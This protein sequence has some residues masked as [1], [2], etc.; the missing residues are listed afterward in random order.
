MSQLCLVETLDD[1]L[2]FKCWAGERREI[3]GV[4]TE[5]SGVDWVRDELRLLCVGDAQTG[6]ALPARE[7]LGP[8]K[9]VVEAYTE[10]I[11]M[12]NSKFDLHFLQRWG[13]DVPT[14]QLHDTML[15]ARLS[16][17]GAP[18][19]LKD[20]AARYVDPGMSV[21][22]D[23]LQRHMTD[24]RLTWGNIP[25]DDPL[26]WS[27]GALDGV[28]TCQLFEAFRSWVPTPIYQLE[29]AVN[30]I[31]YR[32]ELAGIEVDLDYCSRAADEVEQRVA[33]LLEWG[34]EAYGVRNLMS[35]QQLA[36][37]LVADGW[38]PT[39]ITASGAPSTKKAVLE[40]VDHPLATAAIELRHLSKVAESYLR[41]F[42]R[43][44]VDGRIFATTNTLEARTGRMS[45]TNP[46]L[47][48]LTRGDPI[49]RDAFVA[50]QG[51]KL[52]LCDYD[53][54]EL[55]LLASFARE[56]GL[57]DV[58]LGGQDAFTWIAQQIYEDPD[59]Q[60]NDPRRQ[61][62]KN[63]VYAEGYGAGV[64]KM[65]ETAGV[66]YGT[67]QGFVGR[68]R[69]QFPGI[70][71]FHSQVQ[72]VAEQRAQTEGRAYVRTQAGRRQVLP[73]YDER[74][75]YKLVNYL[76]QGTAADVL[77]RA[78]VDLDSAGYGDDLRLLVHDEVILEVPDDEAETIARDVAEI[79]CDDSWYVPLTA[80]SEIYDRWGSKYRD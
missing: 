58:F 30:E 72:A 21:A 29:R 71:R 53:Q 77:K 3:L 37:A 48:T 26:Y 44:A 78:V 47:Q 55:R 17:A 8:V 7:W 74:A 43:L 56:E 38:E 22:D 41:K 64:G 31:V 25:T 1:A 11:V 36:E 76:I 2:A 51:H 15:L 65:A 35:N 80:G 16:D 4:D 19:G 50:G 45:V 46:P 34:R 33:Q 13:V 10:P 75:V 32:M 27:Y 52:V 59:L 39:V 6:W 5:T 12:H 57:R 73:P 20:A 69:A 63:T 24:Q 66:D 61:L 67:M 79:M 60:K 70:A 62:T 18:A 54:I 68:Y 28:M 42:E 49:V 9:E 40:L 14:Y 23:L